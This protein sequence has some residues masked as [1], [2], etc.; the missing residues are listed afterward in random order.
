MNMPHLPIK[1]VALLLTGCLLLVSCSSG[2]GGS[3]KKVVLQG[4]SSDNV[5][6]TGSWELDYSKS[7]N[8]QTKLDSMV[9][10]LQRQAERRS[11]GGNQGAMMVGGSG[12]ANSAPSII[13]LAQMSDLITRSPLL[14]IKQ[15]E[16]EIKVNREENFA[17]SC[18][19]YAGQFQDVETPLGTE[20]CGW[21]GHQFVFKIL[22][23]EGLSIQ[24]VMT[25]ASSGGRLNI[26]TT[27][28]SD[29]VSYP[30]TLNR[31]YNR[32][33]PGGSGFSCKMTLTRGRVCSTQSTPAPTPEPQ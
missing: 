24:H 5:D 25:L 6:F 19:F 22:L 3:S 27:V 11:Q 9:R 4:Q 33:V 32:F 16:H 30:F 31:V 20:I 29:M 26:A 13:G 15:S 23:P 2:G 21:N 1:I 17:L 10:E 12:G 7:D 28:V 18:E 14:K 8:I